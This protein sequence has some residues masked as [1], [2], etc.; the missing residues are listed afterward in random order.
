MKKLGSDMVPFI[1]PS[2]TQ[3]HPAFNP[4]I[5]TSL[6]QVIRPAHARAPL[7]SV[8]SATVLTVS[9]ALVC[10]HVCLRRPLASS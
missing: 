10:A 8:P 6:P 5:Y 2:R 9:L 1:R 7:L 4:I 3:P